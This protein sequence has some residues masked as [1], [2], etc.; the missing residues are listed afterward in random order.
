[1][2][3]TA[4]PRKR[5]P[6]AERREVILETAGRL[7]AEHGYAATRLDDV[8]AAIGVTKPLLYRHFDSKRA[9]Y[10]ALLERHRDDLP[11]FTEAMPAE[12]S[13]D[14]RLRAVLDAWLTYV[15]AHSY[16]WQMLFRDSGGGPEI[17][18]FRG[19]VHTRA[20]AVLAEIVGGISERPI[21]AAERDAIAEML[22]MGM[23]GLVLWWM[24]SREVDR[25]AILDAIS[26]IWVG[27]LAS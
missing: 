1:M 10:L 17:Q 25:T 9:L 19:E 13:L 4:A 12:G 26:R 6:R 22:S 23:A 24:E 2:A 8:A 20:R 18:A 16:A 11:T 3:E 7:F 14:D 5:L 27:V 21:P 15:E